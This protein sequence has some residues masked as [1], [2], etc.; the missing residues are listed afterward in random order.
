VFTGTPDG[1][2][3]DLQTIVGGTGGLAG[4]R[5]F[6]RASGTFSAATGGTSQYEGFGVRAV[7]PAGA[8]VRA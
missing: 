2:I 1:S 8:A 6:V 4:A 3:V 7:M 5:G